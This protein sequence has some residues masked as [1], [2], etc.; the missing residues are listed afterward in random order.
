MKMHSADSTSR[1]VK[2]S[3]IYFVFIMRNSAF[4]LQVNVDDADAHNKKDLK[5]AFDFG[6]GS[7]AA[8][9]VLYAAMIVEP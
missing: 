9:K 1:Y 7:S 8:I 4:A 6:A 3:P 2:K 5:E